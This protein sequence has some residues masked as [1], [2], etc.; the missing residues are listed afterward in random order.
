M[1]RSRKVA[2]VLMSVSPLLLTACASEEKL[3]QGLYTS[4]EACTTQTGDRESC[5]KSFAAASSEHEASAPKY[6]NREACEAEHGAGQCESSRSSSSMFMPIMAGYLMGR[7]MSG[8]KVAGLQSSPVF[9]DAKGGWQRPAS[10]GSSG[11]YRPGS[12]GGRPS[13]PVQMAPNQAPTV[14]RGG[15]GGDNDRRSSG[16]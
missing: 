10:P 7:M 13:A 15:F 12:L 14:S 4:V 2:L 6:A 9:R 8:N 3:E 11:V 16:G 5:E 1:K